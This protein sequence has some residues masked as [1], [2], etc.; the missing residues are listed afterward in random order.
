MLLLMGSAD[1][2]VVPVDLQICRDTNALRSQR[3]L[4]GEIGRHRSRTAGGK[5]DIVG[6]ANPIFFLIFIFTRDQRFNIRRDRTQMGL[7]GGIHAGGR[8]IFDLAMHQQPQ[9][10][11]AI[12]FAKIEFQAMRLGESH[13]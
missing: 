3:K 9:R 4:A 1:E 11:T 7:I 13:E 10:T 5:S 2:Y 8:V 12:G 6:D